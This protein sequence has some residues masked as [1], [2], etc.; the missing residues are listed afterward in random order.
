MLRFD[1]NTLKFIDVFIDDTGGV[2]HLNRP[3]G[4]VFDPNG[5]KLYITS[6]CDLASE[7]P[8]ASNRDSIRVYD[9]TK[10]NTFLGQ[11]NLD[12][13][14]RAFAQA[15][16][17]GPG[18]Y[19]FVPMSN[20]GEIRKCNVDTSMYTYTTFIAPGAL[21]APFYLTF[22]RTDSATLAYPDQ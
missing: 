20:T 13:G 5:K 16:L 17:F 15:L 19:L 2:G 12:Q 4:L 9:A 14:S 3:E 1:P 6:F 11:I 8:K 18:G 22:G 21:G 10:R 7:C